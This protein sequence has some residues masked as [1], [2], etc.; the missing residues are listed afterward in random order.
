MCFVCFS[1]QTLTFVLCNIKRVVFVS[2]VE[3]VYC[4]EQPGSLKK[5]VYNSSLKFKNFVMFHTVPIKGHVKLFMCPASRTPKVNGNVICDYETAFLVWAQKLT[6][7][8]VS[9]IRM[10]RQKWHFF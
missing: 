2:E 9:L 4:M 5:T 10:P 7:G 3:S 6:T 1:G 8:G